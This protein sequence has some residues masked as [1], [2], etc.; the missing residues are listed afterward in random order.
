MQISLSGGQEET[1]SRSVDGQEVEAGE[2][3]EDDGRVAGEER[4]GEVVNGE[5]QLMQLY[6]SHV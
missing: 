2:E 6:S 1:E 3:D 4:D 5:V